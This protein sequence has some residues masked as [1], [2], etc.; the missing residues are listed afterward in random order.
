MADR[1][2]VTTRTGYGERVG[3]SFKKIFWGLLFVIGSIVLLARNENHFFVTKVGLNEGEKLVQDADAQQLNPELDGKLVHIQGVTS[4]PA[5]SLQDPRF[6]VEADDLKLIRSVEMYQR[7]ESSSEECHDNYGGSQDCTTTYDYKK[8]WSDSAIDSSRFHETQGHQNPAT[9]EYESETREKEP[10]IVGA[11]TL[12]KAFT[13][14]LT[15]DVKLPLN[16]QELKLPAQETEYTSSMN[17]NTETSAATSEMTEQ[18][19]G[20]ASTGEQAT[21]AL[22]PEP[23]NTPSWASSK[24][25]FH[26]DDSMIYVGLDSHSPAVGDMRI[27][28]SVVKTGTVSLVGKQSGNEIT[29]YKTSNGVDLALLANGK[30][31][32]TEMFADAQA[33]NLGL[34]WILRFV[35]LVLMYMGFAMM[36]EFIPT[37]AKVLPPLAGLIGFGTWVIAFAAT[38]VLGLGTIAIAWLV[39]RPIIWIWLLVVAIGGAIVFIKSRKK[40]KKPDPQAK[41]SAEVVEV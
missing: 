6:G 17:N 32:S 18:L 19:S 10:I 24:K 9:R 25:R 33:E 20:D 13:S 41:D 35:W 16:G 37:L 12:D 23:A 28:F 30:K 34:T 15:D 31:S 3:N 4:S 22:T 39:V 21:W 1:V 8:K 14:Q 36:L 29:L 38:L 11:F 40:D 27:R 7:S 2:S 26:V 5:S